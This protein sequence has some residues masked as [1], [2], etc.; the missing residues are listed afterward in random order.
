MATMYNKNNA[1]TLVTEVS[2]TISAALSPI[3]R[4]P[5]SD[6]T[7]AVSAI[8]PVSRANGVEIP[9]SVMVTIVN[10]MAVTLRRS[11]PTTNRGYHYLCSPVLRLTATRAQSRLNPAGSTMFKNLED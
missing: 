9:A 4:I 1:P 3:L 10:S 7:Q 2:H 5:Y 11:A 8:P 6:N